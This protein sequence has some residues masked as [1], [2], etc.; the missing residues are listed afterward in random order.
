MELLVGANTLKL[1]NGATVK[2]GADLTSIKNTLATITPAGVGQISA[3]KV[4]VAAQKSQEDSL[5]V[6]ES[7]ADPV[8]GGFTITFEGVNPD[9][10][11]SDRAS[12]IV[13]TDNNAYA[14]ATFTSARAG[15]AGEQQMT[16]TFDNEIG[17]AHV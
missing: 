6:G 15:S 16:Y 4:S 1:V 14:R 2:Q 5:V 7:F 17:R 11:S 10:T 9:L 12:I 8:F 3:I 13:D